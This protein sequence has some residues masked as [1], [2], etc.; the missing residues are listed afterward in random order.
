MR[1]PGYMTSRGGFPV[2]DTN[3]PNAKTESRDRSAIVVWQGWVCVLETQTIY[4][5]A[6][7]A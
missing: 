3:G 4:M 6:A 2:G 1:R 5:S 7:Y